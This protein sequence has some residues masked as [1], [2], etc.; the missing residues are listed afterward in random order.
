M[1]RKRSWV[2]V[3]ATV[4]QNNLRSGNFRVLVRYVIQSLPF[5]CRVERMSPE[6][7]D[8]HTPTVAASSSPDSGGKKQSVEMHIQQAVNALFLVRNFTMRFVEKQDEC[9]LLAHFNRAPPE[10][11]WNTIISPRNN[12]TFFLILVHTTGH[13]V[14]ITLAVHARQRQSLDSNRCG[15]FVSH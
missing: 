10:E 14:L 6:E 2:H 13:A 7:L 9:S 3:C 4:A 1:C 8:A 5:S 15:S 12:R 11:D